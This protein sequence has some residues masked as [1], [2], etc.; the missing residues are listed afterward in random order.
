MLRIPILTILFTTLAIS[1]FSQ[2]S[3]NR[4]IHKYAK[5]PHAEHVHLGWPVFSIAKAFI[6]EDNE[7]ASI[8]RYIRK[9]NVLSFE[10]GNK[11]VL[12]QDIARLKQELLNEN[13]EELVNVKSQGNKVTILGKIKDDNIIKECILL[14]AEDKESTIVH[15]K[16]NL[17]MDKLNETIEHFK[18]ED[19]ATA[20]N[21]SPQKEEIKE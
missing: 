5:A 4:F 19:K 9:I 1:G 10:T 15:L 3:L 11:Q 2:K 6:K 8:V 12:E 13:Y 14:V 7:D 16:G 18:K 21:V 20:K 17:P